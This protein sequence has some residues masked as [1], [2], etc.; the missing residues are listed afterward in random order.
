[1]GPPFSLALTIAGADAAA[2]AAEQRRHAAAPDAGY[3]EATVGALGRA[4]RDGGADLLAIAW[5]PASGAAAIALA[6]LEAARRSGGALT[7]ALLGWPADAPPPAGAEARTDPPLCLLP[8]SRLDDIGPQLWSMAGGAG[9]QPAGSGQPAVSVIVRSMDR[10]T[11]ADALAAVAAQTWRD[12]EVV[13]VNALGAAHRPPPAVPGLGAARVRVVGTPDGAGLQRPQAANL[14]LQSARGRRLIF[15]DDD[16]RMLPDHLARLAAALD[17]DGTA[18][19][20]YSD[21]DLGEAGPQG[22]V[23]RH[24]FAADFDHVRLTFENYL[25]IH[26]VLFDRLCVDAGLRFDERLPVFEDWDFWLACAALGRFIRV[27]GVSARYEGGTAAASNVF[28]ESAEVRAARQLLFAKWQH[29]LAPELHAELMTRL[30]A[31]F[32]GEQQASAELQ[33]AREENRSLAALA[34]ARETEIGNH[35]AHVAG[36]GERLQ[37]RETEIA[38]LAATR[39]ELDAQLATSQAYAG[40]L[41]AVLAA[42]D[43]EIAALRTELAAREEHARQVAAVLESTKAALGVLQNESPLRAL[44]RTLRRKLSQWRDRVRSAAD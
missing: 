5:P 13:I 35:L 9:D 12:L 43:G 14:G 4:L 17:S 2:L 38:A 44:A 31:S 29:Q 27:P 24:R 20:A 33:A 25:P 41:A 19:A 10:P 34:A 3:D 16:D 23:S 18:L 36:L 7:V 28:A 6:A 8:A 32:R 26:A 21:V 15:L 22:W 1:M 37:A 30:Q 42:R 11:L 40:S 39:R